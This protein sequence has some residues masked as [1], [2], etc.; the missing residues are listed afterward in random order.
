MDD[1]CLIDDPHLLGMARTK[2][3]EAPENSEQEKENTAKS[4]QVGR[5]TQTTSYKKEKEL[6]RGVGSSKKDCDLNDEA[7]ATQ[8]SNL[9]GQQLAIRMSQA[10]A[11]ERSSSRQLNWIEEKGGKNKVKKTLN[12]E[13]K[14]VMKTERL[15]EKMEKMEKNVENEMKNEV[16]GTS[17]SESEDGEDSEKEVVEVRPNAKAH[18]KAKSRPS[19]K[20]AADDSSKPFPGGP[21]NQSY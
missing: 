5:K 7:V 4:E 18:G 1:L 8:A 14:K 10:T 12:K 13:V 15:T 2:T 3:A 20:V 11:V 21:I 16:E 19:D 9:A 17:G 6:R